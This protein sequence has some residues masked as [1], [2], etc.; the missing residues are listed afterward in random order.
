MI[1]SIHYRTAFFFFSSVS[2][3]TVSKILLA[4]RIR[5]RITSSPYAFPEYPICPST[6]T[7]EEELS[8]RLTFPCFCRKV[9]NDDKIKSQ[10]SR[11]RSSMRS[12]SYMFSVGNKESH[13]EGKAVAPWGERARS[14]SGRNMFLFHLLSLRVDNRGKSGLKTWKSLSVT[15]ENCTMRCPVQ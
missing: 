3:T 4:Q 14:S 13:S 9:G 7:Q 11:A 15:A 12:V 8:R 1:S 10:V 5:Q 2:G 6:A